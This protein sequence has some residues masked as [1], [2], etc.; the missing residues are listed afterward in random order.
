MWAL[1]IAL[2][3]LANPNVAAL[4]ETQAL[5]FTDWVFYADAIAYA[6]LASSVERSWRW[7]SSRPCRGCSNSR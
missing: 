7:S 2:V 6:G 1:V 3:V 5:A 4:L